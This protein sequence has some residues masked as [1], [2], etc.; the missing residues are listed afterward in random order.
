M[1]CV[2]KLPKVKSDRKAQISVLLMKLMCI[3]IPILC[4]RV[5]ILGMKVKSRM[6]SLNMQTSLC[7]Y[8]QL[9]VRES[10]GRR[11][12][13]AASDSNNF[14]ISRIIIM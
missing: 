13:C 9:I 5:D 7:K 3:T 12:V 11:A 6:A 2:R 14:V 1:T 8:N 10:D 4:N